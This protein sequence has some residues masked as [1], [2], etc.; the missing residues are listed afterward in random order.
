MFKTVINTFFDI[1]SIDV[2]SFLNL[3]IEISSNT[4]N[5]TAFLPYTRIPVG[6]NIT[7]GKGVFLGRDFFRWI[8]YKSTSII[9]SLRYFFKNFRH[10]GKETTGIFILRKNS[11]FEGLRQTLP[12]IE[13]LPNNRYMVMHMNKYNNDVLEIS[14]RINRSVSITS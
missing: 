7:C 6:K 8:F 1:F 11:N 2:F 9:A 4:I 14:N 5:I 13:L 3:I 12:Y 10:C